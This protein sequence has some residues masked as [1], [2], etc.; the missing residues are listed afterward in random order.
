MDWMYL[1]TRV[2]SI[3]GHGERLSSIGE[4]RHIMVGEVLHACEVGTH[5]WIGCFFQIS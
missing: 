2:S 5:A 3:E 1:P 4:S